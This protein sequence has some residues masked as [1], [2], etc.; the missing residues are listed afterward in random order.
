MLLAS[1]VWVLR[2]MAISN[3]NTFS[4]HYMLPYIFTTTKLLVVTNLHSPSNFFVICAWI[5]DNLTHGLTLSRLELK[6]SHGKNLQRCNNY[7]IIT[8][9]PFLTNNSFLS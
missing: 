6:S 9:E 4:G 7:V 2:R 3:I 5:K 8:Y 1:G